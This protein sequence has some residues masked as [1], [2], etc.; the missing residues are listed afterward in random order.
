M[1]VFAVLGINAHWLASIHSNPSPLL[2][3]ASTLIEVV[4]AVA[5]LWLALCWTTARDIL[6]RP[7]VQWLGVRSFSLYLVHEPIVVL[8]G[9]RFVPLTIVFAIPVALLV[10]QLF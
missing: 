5:F 10:T 3:D 2:F 9:P 1:L 6:E 7:R 8:L 4:A